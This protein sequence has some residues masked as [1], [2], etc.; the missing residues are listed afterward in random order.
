MLAV[1][2]RLMS[3]VSGGCLSA[4]MV[5]SFS[6]VLSP[7]FFS[8][9]LITVPEQVRIKQL[10]LTYYYLIDRGQNFALNGLYFALIGRDFKFC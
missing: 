10:Q 3:K 5:W 8:N 7:A 6:R 9:Q 4:S 2:W 1:V